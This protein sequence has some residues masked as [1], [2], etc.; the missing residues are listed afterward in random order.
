MK[1][2]TIFIENLTQIDFAFVNEA[3]LTL[4]GGSL[5][6]SV[7]VSGE[8]TSDENVVIDFGAAKKCIKQLIDD[9]KQGFDHKLWVMPD[10]GDKNDAESWYLP[11]KARR[12]VAL[13]DQAGRVVVTTP[14]FIVLCPEDAIK[15]CDYSSIATLTKDI[16]AYLNRRLGYNLGFGSV[17]IK[18]KVFL[19]QIPLLPRKAAKTRAVCSFTYVHGLKASTSWGCQNIAHGHLSWL[20]FTDKYD[21][22]VAI[23]DELEEEIMDEV[24]GRIFIWKDNIV[25]GDRDQIW[26]EYRTDRGQFTLLFS[27]EDCPYQILDTETTVEHLASWFCER[28]K[29]RI[30]EMVNRGAAK[31]YFSEGLVKGACV[32]L[33]GKK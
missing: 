20:M 2:A 11:T 9:K 10:A 4:K 13:Y 26:L 15:I 27:K 14:K 32:D 19:D 22:P 31:L 3:S 24:N 16:E 18:T 33:T 5:N 25:S 6:M 29:N 1:R 28:F 17:D 8:I 12:L 30:K 7:E 21:C 23:P